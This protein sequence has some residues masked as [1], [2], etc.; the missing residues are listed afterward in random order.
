MVAETGDAAEV[1][2]TAETG[3]TGLT[4]DAIAPQHAH[5][6]EEFVVPDT[7]GIAPL[8][9]PDSEI[10]ALDGGEGIDELIAAAQ[11][12]AADG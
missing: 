11:G 12:V 6:G 5:D 8:Q 10:D 3:D 1:G 4:G 2:D 7:P 9:V